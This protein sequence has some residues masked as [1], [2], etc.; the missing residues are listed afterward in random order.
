MAKGTKKNILKLVL[1]ALETRNAKRHNFYTNKLC[2][3]IILPKKVRK[4][5]QNLILDKTAQ[6]AQKTKK[7]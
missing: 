6:K 7:V 1:L 3:K 5:R 2:A 4:L